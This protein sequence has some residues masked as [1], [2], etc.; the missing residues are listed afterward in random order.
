MRVS[1]R[2]ADQPRSSLEGRFLPLK[3]CGHFPF[4]ECPADLREQINL[5]YNAR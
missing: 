4:F 5:V 2:F 1:V 3:G